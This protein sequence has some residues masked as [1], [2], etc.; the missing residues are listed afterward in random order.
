MPAPTLGPPPAERL[1][2]LK[3]LYRWVL[4]WAET[5]YGPAALVAIAFVESSFFPIPP[6]VLLIAL[7][8]GLPRKSLW[9]ALLCSIASVLGGILGYYLGMFFYDEVGRRIIDAFH[10]QEHFEHVARLYG[11]NAFLSILAAAFTPIP[12]KVFTIAAGVFHEQVP[13]QTLIIA[14]GLGRSGRF[15]LV[16]GSIYLFG[17][18]IKALLDRY[19][20]AATVTL[21]LLLIAGFVVIKFLF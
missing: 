2:P 17:P 5:P 8:L 11:E 12:F 1:N 6:D 21:L 20:E 16:A 19:L 15:F 7:C 18:P 9:F 14:S 4:Q 3:R 13:L 10:Y